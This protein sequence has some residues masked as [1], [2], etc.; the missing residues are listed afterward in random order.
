M[1][2]DSRITTAAEHLFDQAGFNATGMS[3]LIRATG[4]SSRTV[5][6][7]VAGKNALVGR[8]LAQRHRRFFDQMSFENID[9]VFD[10]LT[11]WSHAE[12]SR[13][14]LF[15]RLQAETGGQ[16]PDIETAVS[17][18][19]ETLRGYLAELVKRH[20]GHADEALTD[21]ILALF[22]G[23]TVA[24]TYRGLDVIEAARGAAHT[25]LSLEATA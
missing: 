11:A 14:C 9:S 20:L 4:L 2:I 19:H 7:H 18:Y 3:R 1:E 22:E 15:F 6:K 21:Q 16:I 5:Y 25:L 10:A 13:G 12:G 17:A 24:A 23:A 8:V